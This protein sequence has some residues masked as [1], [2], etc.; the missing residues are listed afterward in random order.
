MTAFTNI[1]VKV[2]YQKTNCCL[3]S[4]E[5]VNKGISKNVFHMFWFFIRLFIDCLQKY[6]RR[7]F[8]GIPFRDF[9]TNGLDTL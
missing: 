1:L 7:S 5:S 6:L 3:G 9:I 4:K 8:C 2:G